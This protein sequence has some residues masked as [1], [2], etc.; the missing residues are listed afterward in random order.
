M[1]MV[2]LLQICSGGARY[3]GDPSEKNVASDR[4]AQVIRVHRRSQWLR[5][6]IEFMVTGL[7]P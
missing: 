4:I 3:I 5:E 6:V 7:T 2:V 1:M